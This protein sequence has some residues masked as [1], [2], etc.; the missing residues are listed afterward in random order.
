MQ[1]QSPAC[2]SPMVTAPRA[3]RLWTRV[4]TYRGGA[5][6]GGTWGH[7][8]HG[9]GAHEQAAYRQRWFPWLAT[10]PPA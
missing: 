9:G 8:A 2:N 7:N 3:G 10:A 1:G 4:A 6:G 5:H